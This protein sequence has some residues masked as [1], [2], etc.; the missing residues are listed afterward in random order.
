MATSITQHP[1]QARRDSSASEEQTQREKE[2]DAEAL[3][4]LT[5]A[6]SQ[7]IE[8]LERIRSHLVS[9]STNFYLLTYCVHFHPSISLARFVPS[10]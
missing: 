4:Q 1:D 8:H 9:A 6:Q 5:P 7:H 2:Q 10:I 3:G